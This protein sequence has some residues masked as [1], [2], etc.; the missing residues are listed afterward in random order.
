[1]RGHP[2]ISSAKRALRK[3]GNAFV[4]D[5]IGENKAPAGTIKETNGSEC[6]V[7]VEEET[8]TATNVHEQP[9]GSNI[10]SAPG[11]SSA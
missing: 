2:A 11:T 9:E 3:T 8:A 4:A 10:I 1:M 7:L 6:L 5:F